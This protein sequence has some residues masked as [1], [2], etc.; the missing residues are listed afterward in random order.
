MKIPVLLA[1]TN[2]TL[3]VFAEA[4]NPDCGDFSATT[5]V[6]KRSTDR[7]RTWGVLA[8]LME[9]APSTQGLCGHP[10]VV[11]NAAPVQLAADSTH[12]PGR[13]LVP[14]MRDNYAVWLVHSDD[15]GQ[16]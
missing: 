1:T 2:N 13:I 6:F 15:D 8:K 7:G 9:E 16:G 10:P 3:I 5:L 4:R 12:Y 14:H 11:G